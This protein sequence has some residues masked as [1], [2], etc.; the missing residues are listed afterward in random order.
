MV[1]Y[2]NSAVEVAYD[3]IISRG[4]TWYTMVD[5]PVRCPLDS[6]FLFLLTVSG[7]GAGGKF[8]NGEMKEGFRRRSL[9]LY[10]LGHIGLYQGQMA[11]TGHCWVK[12]WSNFGEKKRT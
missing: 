11:S 1:K 8:I 9:N 5:R 4:A 3:Y 6:S 12:Y 2:R 7:G 10:I